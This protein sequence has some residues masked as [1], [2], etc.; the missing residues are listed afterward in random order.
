MDEGTRGLE[1]RPAVHHNGDQPSPRATA[2]TLGG[3]IATVRDELDALLAELDRRRHELLDV[4][5]QVRRHALGAALTTVALVGT[6]AGFVWLGM[7]RRRE[8]RRL[9]AQAGRLRQ[10]MARMI[11]QPERVAAEP[12][13]AGKIVTA[14]ASA[15]VASL[16]KKLLEQGVQRAM[17]RPSTEARGPELD[18]MA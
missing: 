15:A 9:P 11:E 3:E 16:V 4:R 2:E 14:A 13:M 18:Q 12:T 1:A 7:W 10:A 8:R 5:L 6:A 17:L